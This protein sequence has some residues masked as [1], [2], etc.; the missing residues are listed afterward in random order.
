MPDANLS[1]CC[2]C[3][4]GPKDLLDTLGHAQHHSSVPD[5]EVLAVHQLGGRLFH[6]VSR[7][8]LCLLS[9]VTT[10]DGV[11]DYRRRYLWQAGLKVDGD[12]YRGWC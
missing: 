10:R 7:N 6:G 3:R 4:R 12:L 5:A 2:G 1:A 8:A 9:G 11:V